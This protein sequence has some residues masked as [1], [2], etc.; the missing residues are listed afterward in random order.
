MSRRK[1]VV[2]K[3]QVVGL[4]NPHAKRITERPDEANERQPG[5]WEM[6]MVVGGKG[7]TAYAFSTKMAS[8]QN[9][10]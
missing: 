1:R 2:R 3:Q 9:F 5:H 6:D 10:N 4:K 7:T 8:P